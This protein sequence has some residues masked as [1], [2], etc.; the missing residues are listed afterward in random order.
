MSKPRI[1]LA[2]DHPGIFEAVARILEERFEIIGSLG[3]GQALLEAAAKLNPDVIV[4]D[5]SMP[6]LNGIEAANQLKD[7][8]SHARVVFLTVHDDPDFIDAC[9]A[10]GAL[11]YVS[12]SRMALDL[13]P[14]IQEA[15][16]GLR[17]Y[18]GVA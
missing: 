16:K 11:G 10:A 1:L 8:G 12:K 14:A 17:F 3:D 18:S 5:I 13:V 7:L 4:T 15:L 6:V 9:F 2:D